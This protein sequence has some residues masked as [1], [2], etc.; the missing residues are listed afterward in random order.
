MA[1]EF[2]PFLAFAGLAILAM[3]GLV[4]GLALLV[5]ARFSVR[6]RRALRKTAVVTLSVVFAIALVL[7]VLGVRI[8]QQY[9]LNEP[10]VGACGQGNL[11]EAQRLLSRGASPDA[12][13][14]DYAETALIAASGAGHPEVVSLLLRN[15]AHTELQDSYGETAI[16]RAKERGHKEVVSILK[17]AGAVDSPEVFRGY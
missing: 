17:G 4:G 5:W 15:G 14:V 6:Q 3:V 11:A 10:F 2:I 8:R 9:F 13:G 7:T 1:P 16:Q 12:Y